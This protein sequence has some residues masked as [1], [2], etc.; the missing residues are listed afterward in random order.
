M[1]DQR[2]ALH[3]LCASANE[4][5]GREIAAALSG[6]AVLE[7]RPAGIA[8]VVEDAPTLVGNARLKARA[9]M[10]APEN[11]HRL[12]AV[13]DDTG[14]FVLALPEDLG[15]RTARYATGDPDHDRNPD[16]ANRRKLLLALHNQGRV[17]PEE[18]QAYFLTVALVCF[19]D[20]TEILAEGRC[21]G[22]IALEE[23]GSQG[24]GFDPLFV[25]NQEDDRFGDRTF[26]EMSVHEKAALSHR[27]RAFAELV[28]QIAART[29][30]A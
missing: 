20:G 29:R 25:P 17:R 26:A 1:N 2:A 24:F 5:K 6:F 16:R 11:I 10:D 28:R 7:P 30:Q 13:A 18:R 19:P 23:R 3:L 12:A 4:H 21:D 22:F 27:G 14:L 8:D 15:V 9:V